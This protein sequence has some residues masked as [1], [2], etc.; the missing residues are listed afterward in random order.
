M[1]VAP[2]DIPALTGLGYSK[3]KELLLSGEIPS[4]R[5]GKRRVVPIAG[6]SR[7][8]ERRIAECGKDAA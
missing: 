7:W 1:A 2:K 5:C 3:V 4:I 8:L 6:I